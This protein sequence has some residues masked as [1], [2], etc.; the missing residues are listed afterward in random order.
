MAYFTEGVKHKVTDASGTLEVIDLIPK[1]S[2]RKPVDK[3]IS[4]IPLAWHQHACI[5]CPSAIAVANLLWY[6]RGITRQNPVTLPKQ[7]LTD[8]GIK[9]DRKLRALRALERAGLISIEKAVGRAWRIMLQD[10]RP[11]VQK[12]KGT[13]SG[14]GIRS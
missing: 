5:N 11:I 6:R 10:P 12:P 13:A 14:E 7:L 2:N 4:K 9:K 1:A 8:H 3:Y